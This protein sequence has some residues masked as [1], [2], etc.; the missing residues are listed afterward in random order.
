MGKEYGT[1]HVL[2]PDFLLGQRLHVAEEAR[3]GGVELPYGLQ[4]EMLQMEPDLGKPLRILQQVTNDRRKLAGRVVMEQHQRLAELLAAEERLAFAAPQPTPDGPSLSMNLPH[5]TTCN[6]VIEI[7]LMAE[8]DVVPA[9]LQE[10]ACAKGSK[11]RRVCDKASRG[12]HT[13][14][15][16][17]VV[18]ERS[19]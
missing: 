17:H 6:L 11:H 14:V 4:D 16:L 7:A 9:Q 10:P 3:I 2:P 8:S 19:Q 12:G 15:R 13:A 5:H 18:H 1:Q